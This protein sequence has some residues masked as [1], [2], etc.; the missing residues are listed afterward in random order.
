M[1]NSDHYFPVLRWKGAERLALLKLDAN[2]RTHITPIIEFVPREF[3]KPKPLAALLGDKAKQIVLNW[4]W[5][6]LFFVDFSLLGERL[7]AQAVAPFVTAANRHQLQA[8]FVIGLRASASFRSAIRIVL[9]SSDR[10]IILRVNAYELRQIGFQRVLYNLLG[11]FGRH[12]SDVHFILDFQV[13][14]D[15]PPSLAGLFNIIPAVNEWRSFTVLGGAFPKD[16]AHLEKNRQHVLPRNDWLIW[17]DY[18]ELKPKRIPSFGDYGIQHGLFEEHEGKFMN[19][20]ASIRY[21]SDDFWVIM[22]GESVQNEDGPGY[23]QWP[24]WAQLLCEREEYCGPQFSFGDAYIHT[25]SQQCLKTGSPKDWL[26]AGFNHHITFVVHQIHEF[27]AMSNSA[28][29]SLLLGLNPHV[30]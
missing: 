29:S 11:E 9:E 26:A 15:H 2:I 22:R 27:F 4:G 21:T 25:M 14:G 28:G 10:E 17:R 13:I 8:G 6:D 23:E 3:E 5:K 18:T 1:F 7:E 12:P 24:A 20:S 30:R 19:F 16:L